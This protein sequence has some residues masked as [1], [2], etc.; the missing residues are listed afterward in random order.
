[1]GKTLSAFQKNMR[2][3]III[4][5]TAF[6]LLSCNDKNGS[7]RKI[8]ID[9]IQNGN[10]DQSEL[11]WTKIKDK[12]P[13]QD[14]L[15]YDFKADGQP[16]NDLSK[17]IKLD[18]LAFKELVSKV[19][20]YSEW[21]EYLEI[22]Y[23]SKNKIENQEVGIFL[24]KREFDGTDYTFDLIQFDSKGEITKIETIANSWTAAECLG[25]TRATIDLKSNHILQEI[26]QKCYD[27]EAE[28]NEALDSIVNTISLKNLDFKTLKTDTIK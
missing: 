3:L 7:D 25:Y 15:Q 8:E 13:N 9:S 22:F 5:L 20:R 16:L 11:S 23:F 27:E 12:F 24:I 14:I 17:A 2:T 26:L 28:N 1:M 10:S 4:T 6:G 21:K 19:K 18:S